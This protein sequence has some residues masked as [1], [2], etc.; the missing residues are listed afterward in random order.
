MVSELHAAILETPD[1][2]KSHFPGKTGLL[3]STLTHVNEPQINRFTSFLREIH[4]FPGIPIPTLAPSPEG[5]P[6]FVDCLSE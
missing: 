2:Q 4:L 5:W 6:V 1:L 3:P